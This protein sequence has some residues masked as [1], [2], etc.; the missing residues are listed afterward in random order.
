LS[1]DGD[2]RRDEFWDQA[3]AI[4]SQI[5]DTFD[6][7]LNATSETTGLSEPLKQKSSES[8]NTLK[9]IQ[10]RCHSLFTGNQHPGNEPFDSVAVALRDVATKLL[11]HQAAADREADVDAANSLER[12]AD[13]IRNTPRIDLLGMTLEQVAEELPN[14]LPDQNF[15]V[16]RLMGGERSE[17]AEFNA[18][19]LQ[20]VHGETRIADRLRTLLSG[21]AAGASDFDRSRIRESSQIRENSGPSAA[22]PKS[23]DFGYE[24]DSRRSEDDKFPITTVVLLSDGRDLSET[25]LQT[26]SQIA[27]REQVPIS[28]GAVGSLN[29]P[30]DV[31]KVRVRLA[32]RLPQPG[33]IK[34]QLK[35]GT[36]LLAEETVSSF[37]PRKIAVSGSER[38]L[39]VEG[40]GTVETVLAFT[41]EEIG[42]FRYTV[43]VTAA[44]GE[45]FPQRNNVQDVVVHV[46]REKIRILLVDWKPRWETRF[47]LNIFR[48]LDFVELNDIILIV[49]EDGKLQRGAVKGTWP[50]DDA[51]MQ[52]YDIVV[53]GD[54]PSDVLT[55]GEWDSLRRFVQEDG[56][57]LLLLGSGAATLDALGVG[58]YF[59]AG[60]SSPS[61]LMVLSNMCV[62]RAGASHPLTQALGED[63]SWDPESEIA[64][65]H[66][67]LQPLLLAAPGES[68]IVSTR[69][70]GAGKT[71][72][73]GTDQ[74]WK[75]FNPTALT[76]HGALYVNSVSWAVDGDSLEPD[77]ATAQLLLDTPWVTTRETLQIWVGHPPDD[78][79]LEAVSQGKVVATVPVEPVHRASVLGRAVFSSLPAGEVEIRMAE[80]D[81]V[82]PRKVQVLERYPELHFLA[83]N[84]DLLTSLAA[85]TGGQYGWFTD[86][87]NLISHVEPKSLIEKQETIY[88]LW[89]ARIVFGLILLG[90]TVEWVWRK[91]AGL[92]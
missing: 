56:K 34:V 49:S 52:L 58:P 28:S 61:H 92:I 6:D 10:Q 22:Y 87:A 65:W 18:G 86:V 32:V 69:Y 24:S 77:R 44:P 51:T 29:E 31:V 4:Q 8:V 50:Q 9:G 46:R 37:A 36:E 11:E 55:D 85:D 79:K 30:S 64:D 74:F 68:P 25:S 73:L 75:R 54:L 91:L 38:P 47:A 5:D 2:R 83:R 35:H 78:A 70:I 40:S 1:A 66:P 45:I 20:P 84:D 53:L 23:H 21:S 76:A 62:T 71:A 19:D 27:T 16:M 7:I 80:M 48:R 33:E 43:A 3:E 72:Y 81:D 12:A 14:L 13:E 26:V 39:S 90:L 41:P 63:L 60:A 15:E 59:L 17:L 89:D 67:E 88:R 82:E 42:R 57:T